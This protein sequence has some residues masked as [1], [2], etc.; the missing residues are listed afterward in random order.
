MRCNSPGLAAW[1]LMSERLRCAW[2][3]HEGIHMDGLS[4][5]GK[6]RRCEGCADCEEEIEEEIAE[7]K[8][9]TAPD[10]LPEN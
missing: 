8:L 10:E 6:I 7:Q 4:T 5:V 9:E 1:H 3:G 2:C